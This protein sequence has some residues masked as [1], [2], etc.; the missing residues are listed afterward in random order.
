MEQPPKF[1]DTSTLAQLAL[2]HGLRVKHKT[3]LEEIGT[4]ARARRALPRAVDEL[5]SGAIIAPAVAVYTHLKTYEGRN[6]N[7]PS[8]RR[9][10]ILFTVSRISFGGT[11]T[12]STHFSEV[13]L[14]QDGTPIR[15]L[16]GGVEF[17]EQDA[18]AVHGM[19]EELRQEKAS[20]RLPNLSEELSNIVVSEKQN[21]T[22]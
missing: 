2:L 5:M 17:S 11:W 10:G 7:D 4:L 14:E 16:K 12:S 21:T 8:V 15:V 13:A 6:I 3:Q 18:A 22:G 19:V 9:E 1:P 20:G